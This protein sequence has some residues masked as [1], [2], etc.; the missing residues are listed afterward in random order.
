M[1]A[2]VNLSLDQGATFS[3]NIIWKAGTPKVPVN[4]NSYSAIFQVRG[5]VSS[6]TLLLSLSTP[7]SGIVIAS[8]ATLGTLTL[9]AT[10]AQTKALPAGRHA[11]E[12]KAI[13]AQGQ[14]TSLMKGVLTIKAEVARL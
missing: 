5:S 3:R 8:P 13:S 1:A 12:L 7:S 10:P 9:S 6:S 4:L 14:V 11:Y 2:T